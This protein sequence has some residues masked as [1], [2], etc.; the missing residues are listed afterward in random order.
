MRD[1]GYF[2]APESGLPA[3]TGK[4]V[5]ALLLSNLKVFWRKVERE[6]TLFTLLVTKHFPGRLEE[7]EGGSDAEGGDVRHPEVQPRKY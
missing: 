1:L 7:S 3:C 2:S 6:L 4:T 5:S